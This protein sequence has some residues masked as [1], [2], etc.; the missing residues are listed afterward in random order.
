MKL[1]LAISCLIVFVFPGI[2]Q[3]NL[4]NFETIGVDEGLSQNSVYGMYQDK[5]GFLWIGTA[6]GLNRYDGKEI[7]KFKARLSTTE[8]YNANYIRGNIAEDKDEN[9]WYYTENGLYMYNRSTDKIEKKYYPSQPGLN[10][11]DFKVV[12]IDGEQRV[13]LFNPG[14]GIAFYSITTGEFKCFPS[15]VKLGAQDFLPRDACRDGENIWYGVNRL[16][17]FFRFNT[18][19]LTTDHFFRGEEISVIYFVSGGYYKAGPTTIYYYDSLTRNSEP[20]PI[21][22]RKTDQPSV[23]SLLEDHNKTIWIATRYEGLWHYDRATR[24]KVVFQNQVFNNNSLP[25]NNLTGLLM[26]SNKN[27]WVSTEGAGVCRLDT[28]PSLFK[29]SIVSQ[30]QYL[31]ANL[32]V[33]A[34]R[35]DDNQ[36]IWIA[37]FQNPIYLLNL[38]TGEIKNHPKLKQLGITDAGTIAFDSQK[39]I[40]IGHDKFISKVDA[41]GNLLAR[42]EFH[43]PYALTFNKF[44]ELSDGRMMVATSDG[45]MLISQAGKKIELQQHIYGFSANDIKESR[46]GILWVGTRNLGVRQFVKSGNGYK[47]QQIL[48]ENLDVKSIH[49]DRRKPNLMWLAT[50]QGLVRFDWVAKQQKV[51]AE[52]DGMN[53][54]YVYGILED[55]QGRLWCSTNGGICCFDKAKNTFV[56]YTNKDGLQ[57]NEFNSGAFHAGSSGN[58]YFGGVNGVNWLNPREMDVDSISATC[59]ITGLSVSDKQMRD[60]LIRTQHIELPYFKN[61]ISVRFSVFDFSKPAGNKVKYQLINWDKKPQITYDL[62]A[63]YKNLLPGPYTLIF[64]AS[65]TKNHWSKEQKFVITILPPF[66]QR[67]WFYALVTLF[68]LAV[69]SVIF[70]YTI[71]QRYKMRIVELEKQNAL[72]R[73]RRRISMEMHDDIGAN[74]TQIT[75]MSEAAKHKVEKETSLDQIAETS[76]KVMNSMSEII[77]SL[78]PDNKTFDQLM[79]YL[80]D[81]LHNLLESSGINYRIDLPESGDFLLNN[82]SKR[83]IILLMKEAVNNAIKHAKASEISV[84]GK[85]NNNTFEVEIKDNGIGFN[86][87]NGISG[88]GLKNMKDRASEIKCEMKIESQLAKGTAVRFR[89]PLLM[90]SLYH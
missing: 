43:S 9:L 47:Q 57:S 13:W 53:S 67:W 63:E 89:I 14:A 23:V 83:N 84:E 62:K 26:D 87:G 46:D 40:W 28:K 20:L 33:R 86:P 18:R 2:G 78:N 1:G 69:I 5:R 29:T 79:S 49:M 41:S 27:L 81:Q 39:N 15:A 70:E 42:G 60:S 82:A 21:Q 8:P 56:N 76:R 6:D 73:E 11:V 88:N 44:L 4:Q 24:Q 48:F 66:W 30:Q 51:F 7:R 35:E 72:E 55:E 19:S 45:F 75:L 80:R 54:S 50:D 37:S 61:D 16:D 22:I 36:N 38:G 64:S 58:F 65:T 85:L 17:G 32:F 71:R 31:K 74:L 52:A 59:A 3:V 10:R 77:W 90:N 12:F 25:T 34:I 68:A